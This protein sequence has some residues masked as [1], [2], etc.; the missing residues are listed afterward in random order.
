[1]E[2]CKLSSAPF[3]TFLRHGHRRGFTWLLRGALGVL[4]A[5]GIASGPMADIYYIKEKP[6]NA[7]KPLTEEERAKQQTGPKRKAHIGP[8]ILKQEPPVQAPPP[9][10]SEAVQAI[11]KAQESRNPTIKGE[12]ALLVANQTLAKQESALWKRVLF[13]L[14][15]VLAGIAV[16]LGLKWWAD[17]Q[18]PAPPTKR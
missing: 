4:L 2:T 9:A 6:K 15:F 16:V 13:Y 10:E 18:V 8:L 5:L 12:E 7:P 3:L 17:K 14:F 1:M 11:T